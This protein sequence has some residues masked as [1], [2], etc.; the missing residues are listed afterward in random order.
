MQAVFP[1]EG[2][3]GYNFLGC[4]SSRAIAN[5]LMLEG[6]KMNTGNSGP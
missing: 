2:D 6:S 4:G 3:F 5:S 1:H